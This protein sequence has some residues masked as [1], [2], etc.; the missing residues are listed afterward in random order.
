MNKLNK[1][2]KV[3]Q[4]FIKELIKTFPDE[5]LKMKK[6]KYY[7]IE[8]MDSNTKYL[9][10][11]INNN[12]PYMDEISKCNKKF[13]KHSKLFI[14]NDTSY[15]SILRSPSITRNNL[16][17]IWKY[18]H[19]LFILCYSV[20]NLQ[21]IIDDNLLDNTNINKIKANLDNY[22]KL[23]ADIIS[24]NKQALN[25]QEQES[26]TKQNSEIKS[27]EEN[28]MDDFFD[29]SL[30]GSLAKELSE[31]FNEEDM[32]D[33]KNPQDLLAGLL[34]GKTNEGLGK[35]MNTVCSKLDEKMK[36]GELNHEQLFMEANKM[37]GKMD[38]FGGGG[39]NN[40]FANMAKMAASAQNRGNPQMRSGTARKIRRKMRRNRGKKKKQL[41]SLAPPAPPVPPSSPESQDTSTI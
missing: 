19:T 38:L 6:H 23:L 32:K 11:F 31:G 13:F 4:E 24:K 15:K 37:M 9:E 27:N 2:N 10:D 34:Q 12:L 41:S 26:E 20:D 18:L 22:D 36:N 21:T 5:T 33:L 29:N 30:I 40:V 7:K 14:V 35:I 8:D 25:I 3:F 16:N 1:F 28:D 17:M 39:G